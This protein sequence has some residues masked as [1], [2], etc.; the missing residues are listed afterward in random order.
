MYIYGR[1]VSLLFLFLFLLSLSL[2][3]SLLQA[4]GIVIGEN[5][6]RQALV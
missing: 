3:L 2:L 6:A 4:R 1:A 5:D